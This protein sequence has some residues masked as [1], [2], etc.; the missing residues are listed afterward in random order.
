MDCDHG[1]VIL[2]LLGKAVS[3]ASEAAHGHTHCQIVALD[4]TRTD[5]AEWRR[6]AP[7]EEESGKTA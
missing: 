1:G 6:N 5:E 7:I 4:I 3:Q 2:D